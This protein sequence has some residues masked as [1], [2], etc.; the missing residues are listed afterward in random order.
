MAISDTQR[1]TMSDTTTTTTRT[2]TLT[3]R[4]PVKISDAD[5]PVIASA[6][7]KR[8]DNQYESQANRVNK[9]WLKVRQHADGR[10]IV[11]GRDDYD[12]QWQ[13]EANHCYRGGELLEPGADIAAAVLRVATALVERG[14]DDAMLQIAHEC[15][16][17][18]P[19]EE[20]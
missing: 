20:I 14:A 2:I 19:V 11:Y 8:W 9:G 7:H 1:D 3:G 12:T 18:L 17:N 13:G 15:I 6:Y 16:A 4:P 5:W 10:A